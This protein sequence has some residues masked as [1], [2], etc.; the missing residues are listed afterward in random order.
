MGEACFFYNGAIIDQRQTRHPLS[1]FSSSPT[2]SPTRASV[3]Q[4]HCNPDHALFE[5][6]QQVPALL[7]LL[8]C[9]LAPST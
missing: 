4:S 8:I 6:D 2:V 7:S 3:N 9:L 5:F 1:T